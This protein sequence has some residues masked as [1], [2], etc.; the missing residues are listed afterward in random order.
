MEIQRLLKT[1][2]G[3]AMEKKTRTVIRRAIGGVLIAAAAFTVVGSL[4]TNS[5][6]DIL[7]GVMMA[8]IF[9]A[10]GFFLVFK[11]EETPTARPVVG[12]ILV[13]LGLLYLAAEIV[14]GRSDPAAAS[15]LT[16]VIFTMVVFEIPGFILLLKKGKNKEEKIRRRERKEAYKA[17]KAGTLGQNGMKQYIVPMEHTVG[18]PLKSGIMCFAR[19]GD[20]G[21]SI[22]SS[23]VRF[24]ISYEKISD[25]RVTTDVELQKHY[26]S[27]AGWAVAGNA[28]L[29]PLGALLL[30][31]VQER[32][33]KI[34]RKYL[35][36]TYV[37]E[38]QVSHAAFLIPREEEQVKAEKL[39]AQYSPKMSGEVVS[40]DL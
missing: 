29:G 23:G 28:A 6:T 19:F 7:I 38:E 4:V 21:I 20:E 39:V 11:R 34:I 30:G 3:S 25:M 9:G 13:G 1:G 12:M 33:D 36:I 16:G 18:L 8:A 22:E 5:L 31:G 40:F 26:V 37:K 15:S 2:E 35:V 17:Y 10:P 14:S 24:N 27:D 32:T